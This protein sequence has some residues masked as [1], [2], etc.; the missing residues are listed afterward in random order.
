MAAP[1]KKELLAGVLDKLAILR[2]LVGIQK[3][4]FRPF[5]RAV[6]YHAVPECWAETFEQQLR[7]YQKHFVPVGLEDLAHL[8]AGTWPHEKP[9]LII[10]FDDGLRDNAEVAAPLLEKYGF[11]GWF[12]IPTGFIDTPPDRQLDFAKEHDIFTVHGD[13]ETLPYAMSWEQVRYLAEHHV[14]GCHTETHIRLRAE[15][16]EQQLH[17]EIG[18]AKQH[19]E[20]RLEREISVF[21]WVG[22]EAWS[23]SPQAAKHI[24]DA[25]FEASFMTNN[26]LIR[27]G[28]NLLQ[29]HRT[30]IE[31]DWSLAT[32]RFQISGIMD[33][34]YTKKR[35]LVNRLTS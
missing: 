23:Y 20:E 6:N 5:I 22:G 24:R 3:L 19:L 15:L 29:L 26:S 9:G 30:N 12:F 33:F 4:C 27:P 32:V 34:L 1:Q 28:V 25:G 14:V 17:R 35:R 18:D 7:Y 10:S 31:A 13:V 11:I 21:C 8:A 2:A 16:T